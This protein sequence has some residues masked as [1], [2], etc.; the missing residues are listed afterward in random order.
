MAIATTM[1]ISRQG[2][3]MA[4]IRIV[5]VTV[6]VIVTEIVTMTEIEIDLEIRAILGADADAV[7]CPCRLRSGALRMRSRLCRT[8]MMARCLS[9]ISMT[10]RFSTIKA[11]FCK[12][13]TVFRQT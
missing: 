1:V 9:A 10:T 11:S 2:V 5:I 3:I 8:T 13:R 7:Y 4:E 12:A 6:I